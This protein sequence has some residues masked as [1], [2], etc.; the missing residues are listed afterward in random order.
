MELLLDRGELLNLGQK[1]QGLT[2][3]CRAGTCWLTQTGDARDHI[4]RG[5]HQFQVRAKGQLVLYATAR[6]RLQLVAEKA[7]LCPLI[8]AT[9]PLQ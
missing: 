6:C 2:I 7:T 3:V 5:G 4:L 9:A 1:L 8:P